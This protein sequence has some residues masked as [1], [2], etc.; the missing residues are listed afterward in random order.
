M[1]T[2][3]MVDGLSIALDMDTFVHII[4]TLVL[5]V[6][7]LFSVFLE[8]VKNYERFNPD[9]KDRSYIYK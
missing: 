8:R 2:D 5:I 7:V 3:K 6:C 9:N 4:K 1:E